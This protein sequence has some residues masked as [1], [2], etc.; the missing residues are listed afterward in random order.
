MTFELDPCRLRPWR[1]GDQA[2]LVRHANNR[3]V[4]R[5][6]LD[7]FPH[8]YTRAD[9]DAWIASCQQAP[10]DT[11]FAI[12]V[13][14][15]AAGAIEVELKE[16]A[17]R[18]TATMGYWLGEVHWGRGIAT[19][20]VRA[21]TDWAFDAHALVRIQA[22]VF[23]GNPASARVLEKAGYQLEGRLRK[24]VMKEGRLLDRLLYAR[25]ADDPLP[26]A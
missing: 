1:E 15:E 18:K 26:N 8:P 19:A 13:E 24:S 2:A 10:A 21:V 9:A 14:G 3:A 6:L 22:G 4:W 7:P 17:F 11:R 20:A 16:G 12:E 5:H 23:E 25:L